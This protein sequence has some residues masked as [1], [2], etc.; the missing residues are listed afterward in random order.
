MKKRVNSYLPALFLSFLFL[1]TNCGQATPANSPTEAYQQFHSAVQRQDVSAMK[2][3]FSKKTLEG[4]DVFAKKLKIS[5]DEALQTVIKSYK[6]GS[7]KTAEF[8]DEKIDGE[9]ATLE[10]KSSGGKWST[11]QFIKEDNSWKIVIEGLDKF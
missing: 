3:T 1:L 7:P 8:K 2:Q 4:I 10:V 9:K 5:S 11:Y 6:E